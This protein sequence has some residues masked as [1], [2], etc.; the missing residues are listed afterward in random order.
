MSFY[1]PDCLFVYL[2]NRLT[3]WLYIPLSIHLFALWLSIGPSVHL[4]DHP[5]ICLSIWL[6][7]W[8]N[9]CLSVIL[10]TCLSVHTSTCLSV[11]LSPCLSVHPSTC[12]SV[13]LSIRLAI[14]PPTHY[15]VCPTACLTAFLLSVSRSCLFYKYNDGFFQ[16]SMFDCNI[17]FRVMAMSVVF[18]L[19]SVAGTLVG[20]WDVV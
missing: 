20:V 15:S 11:H 14:L 3:V 10:S 16:I 2:T 13:H 8:L 4:F 6:T 5:S 12:L 18:G 9:D 7:D 1:L 17:R 19:L